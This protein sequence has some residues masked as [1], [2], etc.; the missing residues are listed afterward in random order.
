MIAAMS[1][2]RKTF[3]EVLGVKRRASAHDIERAYDR[4]RNEL[5][6]EAAIPDPRRAAMAKVAYSTLSD[7]QARAEYDESLG[8]RATPLRV[9]DLLLRVGLP[10]AVLACVGIGYWLWSS[11]SHG[12]TGEPVV[13]AAR[14]LEDVGSRVGR[15]EATLVSGETRDLGL[16]IETGENE[17]ASACRDVPAGTSL[18]IRQGKTALRA[19]MRAAKPGTDLCLLA[20][21]GAREGVKARAGIPAGQEKL[22][23]ISVAGTAPATSR[24]VTVGRLVQTPAGAAF[25]VKGVDALPNGTPIF[26]GHEALAGIV[27]AP[28]DLA[29]GSVLVFPAARLAELRGTPAQIAQSPAAAEAAEASAPRGLRG[30]TLLSEGFTTLWKEDERNHGLVEVLDDVSKAKVG[31]PVAYWTKWQGV[32]ARPHANHCVVTFGDDD[33]IVADYEQYPSRKGDVVL[34]YCALTR[35][36]VELDDLPV[37]EYHFTILT[38]G[39]PVAESSIR[40]ERRILTPSRLMAIVLVLGLGLLTWVRNRRQAKEQRG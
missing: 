12:G 4:L 24:D 39:K 30:E 8:M 20:A 35:F 28:Q 33:E 5:Q 27:V 19:E 31:L 11:R 34:R 3:Y 15:L 1:A 9:R 14:L 25:T 22:H 7:P 40:L 38:D 2:A 37:G 32:D 36:Q 13:D 10:V 16:A 26:D 23:A 29:P 17:V 21:K 6:R 18:A